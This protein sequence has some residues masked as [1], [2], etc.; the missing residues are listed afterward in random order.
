MRRF[1][2]VLGLLLP[3]IGCPQANPNLDPA[4]SDPVHVTE[5][6]TVETYEAG[7]C[8][9]GLLEAGEECD[10]G[11]TLT[12]SCSPLEEA[13]SI[14]TATCT[15]LNIQ[16]SALCGNGILEFGEQCDD[17]N[18]DLEGCPYGVPSCTVCD[19]D[20][21]TTDGAVRFCGDGHIDESFGEN[22]DDGNDATE[23]CPDGVANCESVGKAASYTPCTQIRNAA[24]GSGERGAV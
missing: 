1:F 21:Q 16:N 10:D 20:C 17:G 3:L 4:E 18:T 13:C 9:N 24:T 11:N 8:G 15:L 5:N 23:D 19:G 22:C 2:S 12:E 6:R 7:T 14:C